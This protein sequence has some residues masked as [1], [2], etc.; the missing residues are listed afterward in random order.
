MRIST[1][2][3]PQ[4]Q[5]ELEKYKG[6]QWDTSLK[7]SGIQA[8]KQVSGLTRAALLC[9]YALACFFT[10]GRNE[11]Y[12]NDFRS[13]KAGKRI[14]FITCSSLTDAAISN[15]FLQIFNFKDLKQTKEEPA[16]TK[17]I[18][19]KVKTE[20]EDDPVSKV[21]FT[22]TQDGLVK[23]VAKL[24]VPTQPKTEPAG[25]PLP[26][27]NAPVKLEPDVPANQE[28]EMPA[29]PKPVVTPTPTLVIP[30]KQEPVSPK[31]NESP[32]AQTTSTAP[33]NLEPVLARP[34]E[35]PAPPQPP[36]QQKKADI[37]SPPVNVPP[38]PKAAPAKAEEVRYKPIDPSQQ[39]PLKVLGKGS[40]IPYY[41]H[42]RGFPNPSGQN[43][44]YNSF[45]VIA[46][47]T[48]LNVAAEIHLGN[49]T[50]FKE[51]QAKN[52][53]DFKAILQGKID[54]LQPQIA[55]KKAEV[56]RIQ[57]Q[58][59]LQKKE[60]VDAISK[61]IA[62]LQEAY[63]RALAKQKEEGLL[64]KKNSEIIANTDKYIAELKALAEEPVLLIHDLEMNKHALNMESDRRKEKN[65]TAVANALK[66]LEDKKKELAEAEKIQPNPANTAALLAKIK[67][68][69]ESIGTFTTALNNQNDLERSKQ[70]LAI[71]RG[72]AEGTLN[73]HDAQA[74]CTMIELEYNLTSIAAA[75]GQKL[76]FYKGPEAATN[77]VNRQKFREAL[78]NPNWRALR[79]G[80]G[81]HW[82]VFVRNPD[83]TVD[84]I[85]DNTR[86]K[87]NTMTIDQLFNSFKDPNEWSKKQVTFYDDNPRNIYSSEVK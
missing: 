42:R 36:V 20:G 10:A 52:P 67:K 77:D 33:P 9:R 46:A 22:A 38:K 29:Q 78:N 62:P 51:L 24:E 7:E 21:K 76:P 80:G 3:Q 48:G 8:I 47:Q 60:K 56:A 15:I 14:I 53:Q 2:S 26:G 55:T 82:W 25:P 70:V 64:T 71:L 50:L 75:E 49:Q 45:A 6:N 23:D 54:E 11:D 16:N 59:N 28:A 40:N 65:N 83:G 13:I 68:L 19:A 58:E 27:E 32:P 85:N 73:E 4:F 61:Q 17:Q 79:V 44:P 84:E 87:M 12:L 39:K 72:E 81:V 66:Q 57:E 31:Q 69:E 18:Q 37:P 41:L 35:V 43:C 30:P 63:D 34:K 1:G 86:G 5:Q 74:V